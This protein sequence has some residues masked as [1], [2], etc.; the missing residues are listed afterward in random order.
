MVLDDA[1]PRIVPMTLNTTGPLLPCNS[2]HAD[3]AAAELSVVEDA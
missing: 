1:G 2:Q 3:R